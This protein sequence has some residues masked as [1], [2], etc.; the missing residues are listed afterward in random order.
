MT[1]SAGP[2]ASASPAPV[3][4]RLPPP[5]PSP[6]SRGAVNL[7]GIGVSVALGA[8]AGFAGIRFGRQLA[9][10]KVLGATELVVFLLW[11]P[12]AWLIAV[13]WHE[14]GHLL[15][16][17]RVGGRFLLLVV[18]PFKW[19][20]TP[21]GVRFGL[22]R[23]LNAAGG[24]AASMPTDDRD[25][26]RRLAV[27][28]AGGPAASLVLALAMAGLAAWIGRAVWPLG[29]GMAV[30]LGGISALLFAVTVFPARMGGFKSDGLRF[31]SL[32]RGG[33]GAVQEAALLSLTVATLGGVR[34]ADYDP[35]K[36]AAATT[37]DDGSLFAVYGQLN[38]F[39]HF[40]D[41]RDFAAAQARLDRVIAGEAELPGFLREV[42]RAEYAWL[43]GAA[44]VGG[45]GEAAAMAG[46]ARAWFTSAGKV[47]YDVATRHRA[48]A[49]VLLAEGRRT[50]AAAAARAGL[51]ATETSSMAP[52]RNAFATDALTDLLRRAEA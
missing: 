7:L 35:E 32:L 8:A 37:P 47:A 42:A 38:A 1:P 28:V 19:V 34:P 33:P 14:G 43:L 48:E 41:R 17:R 6:V 39:H 49:A 13:A 27:M 22:N 46:A 52:V 45:A 21:A 40:A 26:P 23:S 44:A 25:L 4:P 31:Y 3:V 36:L 29:H 10:L 50:E 2:A 12:L 11:L 15:A 16:G 24:L 51:L 9:D 20:R 30:V 5:P 18:G